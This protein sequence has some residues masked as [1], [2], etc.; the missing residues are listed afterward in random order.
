MSSGYVNEPLYAAEPDTN[1]L[2]PVWQLADWLTAT[3]LHLALGLVI[4]LIA[5]RAMRSC[6]L[7]WTWAAA[8]LAG[9]VLGRSIVGGGAS[10]TLGTAALCATVR[11]RRWHREDLETGADL[12]DIAAE[13]NGPLDALRALLGSIETRRHTQAPTAAAAGAGLPGD[14]LIVGHERGGRPVA[15]P[16]GG[17]SGG[18][19]TL[20]LGA[21]GSGKTVTMTWAA[22]HA[23]ARGWAAIVIDPKGD[24]DLRRGLADAA[25]KASRPFI[26]WSPQGPSLYNP[27]A[28][29][30]ETEIADKLLAAEPFTEPHYLRQAQ[31]YL[32]HV[33]RSLRRADVAVSLQSIVDHLD[34]ASLEL[35]VRS[36]PQKDAQATHDYLDGLNARQHRDLAGVRDRLAILAESDVGRWL[37]PRTADAQQIELLAAIRAGAVVYFDLQADRRPL[38]TQMLGAA[39]VQDLQTAVAALQARPAPAL[40]M[41]DEFSA[42]APE[43][44]ARLFARARS[45]GVSLLLGTQELSDLRLPGRERLLDQV[46]GN[47]SALIVHRQ[48]VPSSAELIAGMTETRGVWRTSRRGDGTI[49][50]TRSFQNALQAAQVMSLGQGWAAVI[51]PAEGGSVSIARIC[52]LPRSR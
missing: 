3:T 43:Q 26:E 44:T 36:V 35:L 24:G 20:V 28:R 8:T 15:I 4:G 30:G 40:V 11:G 46:L 23:I 37:D 51:V 21:A 45:A 9:V 27:Y 29:G 49:T 47:L 13:R 39:I 17:P 7:R 50:R 6:H 32:G 10:L 42:I 19:H 34:P 5:A 48:V 12:A 18:T 31:R 2:A 16:Q 52:S 14:R 38:L 1:P 33:V 41:I 22:A 25:R